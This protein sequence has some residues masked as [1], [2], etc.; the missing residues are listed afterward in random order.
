MHSYFSLHHSGATKQPF[1]E[2]V[3][4]VTA[5]AVHADTGKVGLKPLGQRLAPWSVLKIAGGTWPA[6]ALALEDPGGGVVQQFTLPLVDFGEMDLEASGCLRRG[7]IDI[8]SL[9]PGP[10]SEDHFI[11]Y[12]Q[13][14]NL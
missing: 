10:I 9:T 6:T 1:D 5:L 14:Q 2:D 12:A 7:L 4:L 3:V 8:E 13:Y 11:V